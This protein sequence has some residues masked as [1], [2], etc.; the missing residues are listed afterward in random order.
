MNWEKLHIIMKTFT[1]VRSIANVMR[2]LSIAWILSG[3]CCFFS[4]RWID[5]FL[6]SFG[7]EQM[8]H[9]LAEICNLLKAMC[10]GFF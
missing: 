1:R 9:A 2:V 8:P 6:A 4:D 7:V 5:S 3:V 10:Y